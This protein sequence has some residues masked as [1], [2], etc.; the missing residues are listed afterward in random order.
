MAIG[1]VANGM[2]GKDVLSRDANAQLWAM[3]LQYSFIV[4]GS[5]PVHNL[6]TA[7]VDNFPPFLDPTVRILLNV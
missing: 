4:I 3:A 6:G 2:V 7:L 5:G 1:L